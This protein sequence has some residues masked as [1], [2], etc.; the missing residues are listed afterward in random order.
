MDRRQLPVSRF[1]CNHGPALRMAALQGFGLVMQPRILLAGDV[2]AG[3]LVTVRGNA[4][5]PPLPVHLVYPH[6]RRQLPKL[7]TFID[8]VVSRFGTSLDGD[9]KL[10]RSS[11]VPV[12]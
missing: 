10:S 6:S 8:F 3:R 12:R 2:A 9:G 4:V 7:R 1:E 5:P 11:R